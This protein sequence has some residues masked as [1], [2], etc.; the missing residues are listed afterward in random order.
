MDLVRFLL[1][2]FCLWALP[3]SEVRAD[4]PGLVRGPLEI[5]E[6][7]DFRLDSEDLS[8]DL[9][10]TGPPKVV[11]EIN[12][13]GASY[14]A[15][16][17]ETLSLAPGDFLVVRS[18]ENK[19]IL[20]YGGVSIAN[21]SEA[22]WTVPVPGD[23]GILELYRLSDLSESRFVVD[24]YAR[25][26]SAEE[27]AARNPERDICGVDD[28]E[29]A[30]CYAMSEPEIYG[31]SRTVARLYI[32]GTS[33]CTG[34]L[35][36][37]EGHVMTNEHCI[38]SQ[39]EASNTT[40]E[41]LAEGATCETE[42]A[43]D[44]S[45]CPGVVASSFATLVKTNV[46]MDYALLQLPNN[47]TAN[48]GYLQMRRGGASPDERIYL[49]QHPLGWGKR[50]A[51]FST[52][53]QDASG[54]A[55]LESLNVFGGNTFWLY[56]ADTQQGA[57]GGPVIAY[58]DHQVVALHYFAFGC[59]IGNAGTA[60]EEIIEDLGSDLPRDAVNYN[61]E[62]ELQGD[63]M[64]TVTSDV[65]TIDCPAECAGVFGHENIVTLTA[66]PGDGSR[67]DG[68]AGEGS[69]CLGTDSCQMVMTQDY[70][71]K[72]LFAPETFTLT[73]TKVGD[74]QGDVVSD[75]AG[76]DC[77]A[78]CTGLYDYGT[79]VQLQASG[80]F[81]RWSGDPDCQDGLVTVESALVCEAEFVAPES[82]IFADGFETGDC[83]PW[84]ELL[85]N[86]SC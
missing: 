79:E 37:S 54:F 25:G 49:P 81:F 73:V 27:I 59:N 61:L 76:I 36:G 2:P 80:D 67:F 20:R 44:P 24:Q 84:S 16:H 50:I 38:P 31:K 22:F 19:R 66:S 60:I 35:V 14:I 40:F 9:G 3:A 82:L 55:E 65:G 5:A 7:M 75:P 4:S 12:H 30:P 8:A 86:G 71:I 23:R 39:F 17:F 57:S 11:A 34:W 83:T 85:G 63:G 68:W 69:A 58:A 41:F 51:V 53:A 74:G 26:F 78:D 10:A 28:S 15:V 33:Y 18:A 72:A 32:D 42:C 52:E 43:G 64:G 48:Y 56:A 45:T 47:P 46:T 6:K 13:P 1:A 21:R 70:A 77:G 29:W 62:V